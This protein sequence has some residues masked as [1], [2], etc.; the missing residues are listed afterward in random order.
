MNIIQVKIEQARKI[1]RKA[2]E[3]GEGQTPAYNLEL[4]ELVNGLKVGEGGIEI[5]NAFLNA[6]HKACDVDF[7]FD[8]Y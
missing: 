6:W 7:G 4:M 2:Y 3:N 5:M 1:G 8:Q